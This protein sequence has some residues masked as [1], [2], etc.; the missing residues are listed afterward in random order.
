MN[1]STNCYTG[2]RSRIRAKL[3]VNTFRGAVR[4]ALGT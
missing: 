4:I 2:G 3:G 1:T